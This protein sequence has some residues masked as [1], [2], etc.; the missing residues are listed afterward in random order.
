MNTSST[1]VG[2]IASAGLQVQWEP[3][4]WGRKR[5]EA[6]EIKEQE[7]EA[8]LRQADT[9]ASIT[10]QIRG[11]WRKLREAR[12]LLDIS[13]L[14]QDSARES[15]RETQIRFEQKAALLRDVLDT[16]TA[17]ANADDEMRRA[18]AQFWSARADFDRAVGSEKEAN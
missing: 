3:F 15:V 9:A 5:H 1:L 12:E 17:K 2:N 6:A 8:R 7:T 16:Q 4:D 14:K 11:A 10:T 18:L 13:R